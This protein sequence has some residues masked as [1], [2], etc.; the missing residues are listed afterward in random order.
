MINS[1]VGSK[2]KKQMKEETNA[3]IL[4]YWKSNWCK[5]KF[6]QKW[7]KNKLKEFWSIL[8][9]KEKNLAKKITF[10]DE[11]KIE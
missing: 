8:K 7:Q 11:E 9:I 6:L 3:S 2:K 10:K 5:S 4:Q 1:S